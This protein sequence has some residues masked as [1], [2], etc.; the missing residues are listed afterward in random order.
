MPDEPIA[1]L[2]E[3]RFVALGELPGELLGRLV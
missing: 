3:L 1:A 2:T